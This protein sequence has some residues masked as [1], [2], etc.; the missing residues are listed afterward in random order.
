MSKLP[1]AKSK[2]AP[3]DHVKSWLSHAQKEKL[4]APKRLEETAKFLVAII[5]ISLT[6]FIS[7]RPEDM[8]PTTDKTFI[9]VAIIWMISVLLSF[10]VLFPWRYKFNPES[11][12][13]IE[14]AYRK[15]TNTKR[16]I[17]MLSLVFY[18]VALGMAAFAF[19]NGF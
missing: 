18:L 7:D 1:I 2:G 12:E 11:V 17:L 9:W 10:F 5:S 19:I 15:I 16:W 13:D 3:T 14:R 6:I 8:E 4:E